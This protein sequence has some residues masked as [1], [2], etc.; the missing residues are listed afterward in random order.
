MK[1]NQLTE[2]SH[3]KWNSSTKQWKIDCEMQR[4]KT[5]QDNEFNALKLKVDLS[6][7]EFKGKRSKE[8]E[9]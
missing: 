1:I 5:R 9:K 2:A 8:L 6:L 7:N 4:L 3:D